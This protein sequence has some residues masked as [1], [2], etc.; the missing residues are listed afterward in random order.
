MSATIWPS[1]MLTG[2]AALDDWHHDIFAMLKILPSIK[3]HE[4]SACYGVLVM[5]VERAFAMEEQWME[6]VDFPLLK[7]HREQHARVLGALHHVHSRVIDGDFLL[8]REVTERLLP[9]WLVF[10]I[11]TM[12]AVLAIEMQIAGKET[13]HSDFVSSFAHAD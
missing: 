6:E 1:E 8:G 9:Q 5:K 12:D 2:A 3:E 10:H 7:S 11:S 13:M 4:F